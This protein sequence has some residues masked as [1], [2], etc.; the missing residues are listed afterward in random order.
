VE[1][2]SDR[3]SPRVDEDLDRLTRSVTHGAPVESRAEEEREQEGPADREPQL[4]QDEVQAR[5]EL[6]RWLRPSAFPADRSGL[7]AAARDEQAPEPV[8][9]TL[10]RLPAGVAYDNVEQ[11]WEALGGRREQRF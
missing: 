11:V 3:H 5:S 6:A 1:R 8:A 4:P 7:L 9:E 10:G 2:S